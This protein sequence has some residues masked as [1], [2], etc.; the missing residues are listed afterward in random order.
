M[1]SSAK[2]ISDQ[3]NWNLWL[4]H[5]GLPDEEKIN[6]FTNKYAD[7]VENMVNLFYENKLPENFVKIYKGWFTLLKQNFL[8]RIKETNK[9]LTDEQ[10]SYLSDT[11]NLKTGYDVEVTTLYFLIVLEHGKILK[12]EVIEALIDFLGKHGRI[13]YIRPLYKDFYLRDKK[14]AL[15][16]LNKYRNF[17]HAI[18]IKYVELDLKT[19]G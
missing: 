1:P 5:P 14:R 3:I 2:N 6:N 18:I 17:Y 16:T 9:E 10:L 13:N 4:Y 19:L 15:E 12:E 8:N 11:L 7:E